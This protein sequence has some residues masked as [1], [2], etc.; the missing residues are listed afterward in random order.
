MSTQAPATSPVRV[1]TIAGLLVGAVG[2]VLQKLGGITMPVVPPGLII[3]VVAAGLMLNPKWRWATIVAVLAG[4]AEL[5]GF[6]GSNAASWLTRSDEIVAMGGS[7][8]RL[9]GI[10]TA[11]VAGAL[12]IR[13]AYSKSAKAVHA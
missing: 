13:A 8:V 3:L 10:T 1:W 5:G 2:L 6:F 4:L 9:I 7:W 11:T 12:A